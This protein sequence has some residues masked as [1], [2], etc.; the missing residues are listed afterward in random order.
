MVGWFDP[1]LLALTA[2]QA[3]G[4]Q[5]FG[6]YLDKREIEVLLDK[7]EP[8]IRSSSAAAAVWLDYVADLGDGFDPTYAIAWH[9]AKPELDVADGDQQL[10]L[11]RGEYLVMGGDEVYPAPTRHRYLNQTVGPYAAA[12]PRS[13]GPEPRPQLLA[14]PGNHD[15]YDGLSLFIE[16][17]C[18]ATAIGGWELPQSRSYFAI[19]LPENWWLW[20]VDA[21]LG[22]HIDLPQTKYFEDLDVGEGARII[23]CWAK[24]T[25]A[26]RRSKPGEHELLARF[27]RQCIPEHATVPLYLSGDSHHFAHYRS[28]DEDVHW[29]TAGG[30][31]AFLHPTH[32][33]D[34]HVELPDESGAITHLDLVDDDPWPSKRRSRR[35]LLRLLAFPRYNPSFLLFTAAL[36]LILAWA[37]QF[38]L[39]GDDESFAGSLEDL[40]FGEV[41]W[42]GFVRNPVSLLLG[43]LVIVGFYGF[44]KPPQK[45]KNGYRLYGALH[46]VLHVTLALLLIR[47]LSQWLDPLGDSALFSVA[48]LVGVG[49]AGG[50]FSGVLVGFYLLATNLVCH[51]HDN[52][53]FSALHHT[54]FKHFLRIRIDSTGLTLYLIGLEEVGKRWYKPRSAAERLP[55]CDN[56]E[57][58]VPRC[59]R[60]I[61]IATANQGPP[62]PPTT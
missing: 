41:F 23:L 42:G 6:T 46:G 52:E 47:Y 12:F 10:K 49:I 21:G 58:V 5:T 1:R 36:H 4:A 24:S 61:R 54:G 15:W 30:G 62:R 9:L 19:P 20:A 44:A 38:G 16:Q 43:L 56:A 27:V 3:V 50:L 35:L 22:G 25:W 11:P 32:H 53:A 26:R 55:P 18:T 40:R 8:G 28:R 31:G 7:E 48:F 59:I 13:A 60:T 17:F 29:V 57:E 33:L 2:W 14:L 51:M 37:I 39:R 34:H 45:G